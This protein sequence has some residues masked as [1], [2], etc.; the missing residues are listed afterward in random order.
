MSFLC[1]RLWLE[2]KQ[3]PDPRVTDSRLKRVHCG[4]MGTVGGYEQGVVGSAPAVKRWI[5]EGA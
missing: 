4:A 5:G 3:E 2:L 1:T